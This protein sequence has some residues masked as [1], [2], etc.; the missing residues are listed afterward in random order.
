[1]DSVIILSF[2]FAILKKLEI[3]GGNLMHTKRTLSPTQ[4]SLPALFA[5]L[6]MATFI[7]IAVLAIGLNAVFNQNT[8]TASPAVQPAPQVVVNKPSIR[9]LQAT[10]SQYQE[11]E[12]QYQSELQRAADQINQVNQQ[13][14]QYQNLIQNLQNA[15]V[16]QITADGRLL[17]S[18]NQP[19]RA[20]HFEGDD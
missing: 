17:I 11:R 8:T 9:D 3:L 19:I 4:K 5:A 16:I 7:F 6:T 10:I 20:E 18:N 14:L 12:L 2:S 13:N 1:M 15:G